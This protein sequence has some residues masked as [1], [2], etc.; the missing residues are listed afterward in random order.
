MIFVKLDQGMLHSS[1]W[2]DR[3]AREIFITALLL[4]KPIELKAPMAEIETCSNNET[5][6]EVPIGWYGFVG[7]ASTGIISAS[8]RD[9]QSGMDA[10]QRL[11]GPD[12]VSRNPRF[13]GRRMVRVSGGFIV[14]NYDLYRHKD[15]NTNAA[16]RQRAYRERK[17]RG[18]F[19]RL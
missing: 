2:I 17:K 11:A 8:G 7:A 5:G 12:T 14:L 6:W 10:I 4:A 3:P 1:L 9:I 15:Y 16:E 19:D 18:E 13:D